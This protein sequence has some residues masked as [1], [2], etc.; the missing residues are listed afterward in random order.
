MPSGQ[1]IPYHLR[2]NK[3]VDRYAFL[4]L[5]SKVD[6]FSD[7]ENYT[8]I[9]FGGHS[10]EDFKYVHAQFGIKNMISIE[11]D[12][13]VHS[14]QLF[15]KP[16]SC[17]DCQL[18]SSGDFITRFPQG[19]GFSS[20]EESIVWLDY[21]SPSDLKAQV[22][23]FRTM[24][25]KLQ[26]LD[27]LKITLNAEP[28]SYLSVSDMPEAVK[29]NVG[30]QNDERMSVIKEMLSELFPTVTINRDMM[31]YKRFPTALCKVLEMA[32]ELAME[33]RSEL[34]FKPLTTF[35]YADGQQML[36]VTGILLEKDQVTAFLDK[37]GI[38]QWTLHNST[39]E[40]PRRIDIPNFTVRERLRLDALLPEAEAEDIEKELGFKFDSKDAYSLRMLR[41]YALFYR[42]SPYFSKVFI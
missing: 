29:G 8:Y 14:R 11:Q 38:G 30:A 34:C 5:L 22:V 33:S 2:Q 32:A 15:N 26:V 13:M 10:L 25:S 41:N 31:T 21:V 7:I 37:T 16:H 19:K 17:I 18:I 3:A 12:E 4:D 42:Q 35:S 40:N 27:I 23:E 28:A 39:W 36:T 1:S 20:I 9:G 24:L 6:K